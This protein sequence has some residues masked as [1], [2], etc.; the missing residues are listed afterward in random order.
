MAAGDKDM[1][2]VSEAAR[3]SVVSVARWFVFGT[4]CTQ[5]TVQRGAA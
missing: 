1:L 4:E 5:G 3:P 2:R